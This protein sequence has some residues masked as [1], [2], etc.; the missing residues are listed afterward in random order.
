MLISYISTIIQIVQHWLPDGLAFLNLHV[1]VFFYFETFVWC[2]V[3]P[4]RKSEGERLFTWLNKMVCCCWV[5]RVIWG[6]LAGWGTVTLVWVLTL[7][8][9]LGSICGGCLVFKV[10]TPPPVTVNETL[11]WEMF[12]GLGPIYGGYKYVGV[13]FFLYVVQ[14]GKYNLTPLRA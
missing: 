14:W 1:I 7:P 11:V 6:L 4:E 8:G 2:C 10:F 9:G 5:G 13:A 3:A 12:T